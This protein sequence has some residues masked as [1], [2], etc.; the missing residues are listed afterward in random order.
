LEG[1]DLHNV[2]STQDPDFHAALKRTIGSLYTTTAVV[3]LEHHIDNCTRVFLSKMQEMIEL[4]KPTGVDMSAWL[5]YYAFDSLGEINFSKRLGFLDTG[6]DIDGI[7]ELD[8]KQMMYFA[9][10]CYPPSFNHFYSLM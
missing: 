8:H 6:T 9:L 3:K 7:C 1:A 4:Q 2:F 10:V 5:Q